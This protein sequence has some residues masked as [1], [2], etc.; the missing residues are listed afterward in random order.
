M[1]ALAA[2]FVALLGLSPEVAALVA[3][4]FVDLGMVGAGAAIVQLSNTMTN[5]WP[6]ASD[7]E[8]VAY[9]NQLWSCLMQA[10]TALGL[11]PTPPP[12]VESKDELNLLIASALADL[13]Q[14]ASRFP[15]TQPPTTTTPIPTT[16]PTTTPTPPAPTTQPPTTA[17]YLTYIASGS[18]VAPLFATRSD[19]AAWAATVTAAHNAGQI[20]DY[21]F[22]VLV[23]YDIFYDTYLLGLRP[24]APTIAEAQKQ[25]QL[26]G[27]IPTTA[28]TTTMP[29]TIT[30]TPTT[31]LAPTVN[32]TL[33]PTTVTNI[34]NPPM[35]T[36]V[37]DT[38]ALTQSLPLIGTGVAAAMVAAAADLGQGLCQGR[39]R[40]FQSTGTAM[41]SN[42]LQ[43][44]APLALTLSLDKFGPFRSVLDGLFTK[45][46][47]EV[48]G[49]PALQAPVKPDQAP[50]V[51]RALFMKALEAGMTA[52][53]VS[54]VAESFAPLKNLGLGY[55]A[56]FLT[57]MSGF[58]KIGGAMMAAIDSQALAIPFKYYINQHVRSILPDAR[59]ASM[60]FAGGQIS[61]D[62]YHNLLAYN[63]IAPEYVKGYE[64]EAYRAPSPFYLAWVA[65]A[66]IYDASIYTNELKRGNYSDEF[67]QV[68]LKMLNARANGELK[69][70]YISVI[71][72]RFKE[73]WD[74]EAQF[75]T[76]LT[77][78]GVQPPILPK[79]VYG[80]RLAADY[81]NKLDYLT[82][83][84]D[85]VAKGIMTP[86]DMKAALVSKGMDD[87]KAK[88]YAAIAGIGLIKVKQVSSEPTYRPVDVSSATTRFKEGWDT[89]A[90]FTSN[91]IALGV[92]PALLSEY[93]YAANLS[94]DYDNKLD[95][96]TALKD[97]VAKGVMGPDYMEQMLV[98]RGMNADKAHSYAQ[99]AAL[100]LLK[101]RP[102]AAAEG[103]VISVQ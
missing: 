103:G 34:V 24:S 23:S 28:P 14:Y 65:D 79:Y 22:S 91:L 52:H 73:G 12:S 15:A 10:Q 4:V 56:A 1:G 3:Q 48:L 72:T 27:Q 71:E 20:S 36:N 57:D 59:M 29:T 88:N 92:N 54:T 74:D 78:L 19:L 35:I 95:Y 101:A 61:A 46:W 98:N 89:E 18:I 77:A 100:G 64:Y 5:K 33:P 7:N 51:S 30:T 37:V 76:N 38:S 55:L 83:L 93:V 17:E 42:I 21:T 32:V 16:P 11:V 67:T 47:D 63:G 82:T 68:M 45:A 97:A 43:A 50:E 58:A 96:L 49:D 39:N 84:K 44:A 6:T 81:D 86:E 31:A 53:L 2:F 66:G 87:D 9:F 25:A 41:L 69:T 90:Q 99:I 8:K 40:C 102:K 75:T 70:L 94:A 13:A 80:A 62:D 26:A 85:A 60:L